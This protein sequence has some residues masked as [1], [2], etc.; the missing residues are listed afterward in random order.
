[1]REKLI[2]DLGAMQGLVR[3]G[4][5]LAQHRNP[6]GMVGGGHRSLVA[7]LVEDHAD[8]G[9]PVTLLGGCALSARIKPDALT[10]CLENLVSNAIKYGG[11]AEVECRCDGRA[12]TITVADRGPGIPPDRIEAMFEPFVRGETSRSRATGGTGIGLTIARKQAESFGATLVLANR[13]GGGLVATLAFAAPGADPPR[14]FSVNTAATAEASASPSSP[15]AKCP[16]PS[17]SAPQ[18]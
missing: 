6:R 15:A 4:L 2:A 9:E 11:A 1:L 12:M 16:V 10:R 17:R 14:T 18:P 3:D 7:S 5:D 13:A 8:M